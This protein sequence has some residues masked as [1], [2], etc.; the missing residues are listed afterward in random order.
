MCPIIFN[1][2]TIELTVHTSCYC[3]ELTLFWYLYLKFRRLM[4]PSTSARCWLPSLTRRQLMYH[5]LLDNPPSF[6]TIQPGKPK[7]YWWLKSILGDFKVFWVT[8]KKTSSLQHN[9][10]RSFCCI[11]ILW[12]PTTSIIFSVL[13]VSFSYCGN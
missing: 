8:F 6:Q 3:L 13:F 5:S 2:N 7:K 11:L 10:L 9:I 1:S 4:V 12:R